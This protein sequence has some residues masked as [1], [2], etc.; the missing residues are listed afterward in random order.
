MEQIENV[1]WQVSFLKKKN[2]LKARKLL[3]EAIEVYP[4]DIELKKTLAELYMLKRLYKKAVH[5]YQRALLIEPEQPMIRFQLGNCFLS[6]LEYKLAL[7][8]YDQIE[9]TFAELLYNKAFALARLNKTDEAVEVLESML[10]IPANINSELPYIFLAE[11]HYTRREFDKTIDYL[12][13]AEKAFGRKGSIHYL[14]G[15]TYLNQENWL[16]A[17]LEFENAAK[18]KIDTPHFLKNHGL[19]A[20]KIGK[21]V[22]AIDLM[23]QSIKKAPLDS[24]GYIEL[25]KIYLAHERV[26]EAYSIAQHARK[27]IPFSITLSML[28]D[29]IL[30][31]VDYDLNLKKE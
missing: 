16:K 27:N 31:R 29:Q 19:A 18:L 25:I 2:W 28:Y 22:Q 20:E 12:M 11:L 8:Y 1:L 26:M 21:T 30:R 24:G 23:L 17:Y 13:I 9:E 14:R 6:L 5:L 4:Q 10:R 7:N 3:L 15:L